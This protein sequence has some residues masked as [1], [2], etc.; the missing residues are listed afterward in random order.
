M[1]VP[2]LP[3]ALTREELNEPGMKRLMA[4]L[5]ERLQVKREINDKSAPLEKTEFLRGEIAQLKA[6]TGLVKKEPAT[7]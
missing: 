6:I 3:F 5:Q 7:G 2:V 1:S 4:H